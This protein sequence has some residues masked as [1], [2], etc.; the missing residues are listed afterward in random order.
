MGLYEV[1]KVYKEKLQQKAYAF[2][3]KEEIEE[4]ADCTFQPNLNR[5]YEFSPQRGENF[6]VNIPRGF[7]KVVERLHLGEYLRLS[8]KEELERYLIK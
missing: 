8:R 6:Y 5:R 4:M 7:K 3:K 2:K 1:A